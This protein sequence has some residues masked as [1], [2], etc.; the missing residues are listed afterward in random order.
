MCLVWCDKSRANKKK[1][2]QRDGRLVEFC[3]DN[4]D[5]VRN[6]TC[7]SIKGNSGSIG[8]FR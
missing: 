8:G 3:L 5:S 4:P 1:F 7:G 2:V 6:L